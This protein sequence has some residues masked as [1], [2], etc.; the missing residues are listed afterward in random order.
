MEFKQP[1]TKMNRPI[2]YLISITLVCILIL[3]A[4]PQSQA[5]AVTC[6]YKHKVL[7]GETLN[8]IS[9]LYGI[10]WTKI[11][12][13]NNMQPPYTI[14][15]GQVLCIP[16]GEKSANTT[17]NPKKG[18]PP[19]LQVVSGIGAVLVSVENFPKQTSY[20]V[21]I[22]PAKWP[23]SYRLGVFTTNK[24]GDFTDWFKIPMFVRRAPT[25]TL[26]VKNV[27]TDSASCMK[28]PD[29]IFHLNPIN[30]VHEP[31]DKEGR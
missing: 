12:D 30:V 10:S 9:N 11:A 28:Y 2:L 3:S 22:S 31:M 15:P 21:R 26:C 23:V 25:M 19:V 7:Q 16:E 17:P 14:T 27:W 29:L 4:I 20:Y 5:S 24:E 6:K 1:A 18:K 8:Y 13:A